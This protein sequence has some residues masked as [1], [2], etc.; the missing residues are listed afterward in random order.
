MKCQDPLV[1]LGVGEGNQKRLVLKQRGEQPSLWTHSYPGIDRGKSAHVE[2]ATFLAPGIPLLVINLFYFIL[3]CAHPQ[4]SLQWRS[5]FLRWPSA[6]SVLPGAGSRRGWDSP[7]SLPREAARSPVGLSC[8]SEL[9][10]SPTLPVTAG[11]WRLG[12][13]SED[14]AGLVS[15]RM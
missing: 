5:H 6:R 13:P 10:L 14:A 9:K 15:C 8:S 1:K 11:M 4:F 3:G 7:R 12:L 2:S